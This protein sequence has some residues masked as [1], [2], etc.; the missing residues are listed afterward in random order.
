MRYCTGSPVFGVESLTCCALDGA[1]DAEAFVFDVVFVFG[2]KEAPLPWLPAG[3]FSVPVPAAAI[4][5]DAVGTS[6]TTGAVGCVSPTVIELAPIPD[7]VTPA[8]GVPEAD[9]PNV[10]PVLLV[11]TVFAPVFVPAFPPIVAPSVMLLES[12]EP[13]TLTESL[14]VS[15]SLSDEAE[16]FSYTRCLYLEASSFAIAIALSDFA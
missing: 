6:E 4:A 1:L 8:A 14:F 9:V 5:S 7:V 12:F 10:T 11:E 13:T 3:F 16:S 2:S 15:F